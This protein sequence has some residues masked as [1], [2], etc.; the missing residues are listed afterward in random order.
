MS[1][2]C[3]IFRRGPCSKHINCSFLCILCIYCGSRRV[4]FV[5]HTAL[6]VTSLLLYLNVFLEKNNKQNI[7]AQGKRQKHFPSLFVHM[8]ILFLCK[9]TGAICR[10]KYLIFHSVLILIFSA[11]PLME[12]WW[13]RSVPFHVCLFIISLFWCFFDMVLEIYVGTWGTARMG[14]HR[15]HSVAGIWGCRGRRDVKLCDALPSISIKFS[16]KLILFYAKREST[17][18]ILSLLL[19]LGHFGHWSDQSCKEKHCSQSQRETQ[20]NTQHR[21]CYM[22]VLR[23]RSSIQEAAVTE[24]LLHPVSF[25]S[26]KKV[27]IF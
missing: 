24:L 16:Y 1:A 12:Y 17:W 22:K 19:D 13:L 10:S 27:H 15:F 2:L 21:R 6:N 4:S 18:F 8:L 3:N 26:S 7:K 9:W 20:E 25:I 14:L 11:V 23:F 5:S